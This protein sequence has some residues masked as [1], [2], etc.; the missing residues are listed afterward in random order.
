MLHP[1]ARLT[2]PTDPS[3]YLTLGSASGASF[4]IASFMA[5]F[6][7]GGW[8]GVLVAIVTLAG[9]FLVER[10]KRRQKAAD[11]ETRRNND[12]IAQMIRDNQE[13]ARDQALRDLLQTTADLK[14][15]VESL[16]QVLTRPEAETR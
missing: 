13:K 7:A 5:S 8:A 16:T 1:I 11:E 15:R 9:N 3:S 2:L 14:G 10:E 6:P 12:F 4:S